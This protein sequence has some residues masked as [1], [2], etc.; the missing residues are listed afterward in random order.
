MNRHGLLLS[1]FILLV[2]LATWWLLGITPMEQDQPHR[3]TRSLDSYA[4]HLSITSY[5]D[6]GMPQYKLQS[7][8]MRSYQNEETTELDEPRV[9]QFNPGLT[10]W[11]INAEQAM[12]SREGEK[13]FMPGRVVIDREGN[14]ETVPYHIVTQDLHLTTDTAYAETDQAIRIDSRDHWISAMGMQG[15]LKTPI[16]IKLLQQVRGRYETP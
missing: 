3:S 1:V 12:V 13:I 2:A 14:A 6:T 8:R 15:W 9:W 16:R 5:S 7:P 10:P 4:E 11:E